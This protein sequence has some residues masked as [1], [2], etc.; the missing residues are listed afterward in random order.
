MELDSRARI[1]FSEE[2]YK[3]LVFQ[4]L[5]SMEECFKLH[6]WEF[7]AKMLSK[8]MKIVNSLTLFWG[9]YKQIFKVEV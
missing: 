6:H 2:N 4:Q 8:D 1:I 5:G 7:G 9:R 3:N